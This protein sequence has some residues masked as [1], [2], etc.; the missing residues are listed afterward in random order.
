MRRILFSLLAAAVVLPLT[1]CNPYNRLVDADESVRESWAN[2][3]SSYQRRADLVPNL[4][5]TVRGAADFERTT[6][7]D[8]TEARARASGARVAPE[9]L[10]DPEAM[11][12]YVAAQNQ[13]GGALSR[14][15][16]I[17]ENYP[18][19]RA[20]EGFRDLQ[21][22]L[23]GTENRINVARTRYN[24]SVR[25]YNTQVRRFPT[26]M[27]ARITG[28]RTKTPFEAEAGAE[29]APEVDFNFQ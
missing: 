3:E 19:L 21:A 22:Q 25:G 14:L 17:T 18:E 16:A 15:L 9:D 12:A 28:F 23:E 5:S 2:V 27:V 7:Q 13:L 6:L 10:D 1:G 11:A 29:R 26:N 20:T 24:E 4:V 8:V